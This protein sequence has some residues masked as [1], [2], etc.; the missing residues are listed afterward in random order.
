VVAT[1]LGLQSCS[2]KKDVQPAFTLQTGVTLES[3][4]GCIDNFGGQHISIKPTADGYLVSA[5]T[6][7]QCETR[8]VRPFMTA[9]LDRR[10]TLVLGHGVRGR[11]CECP[12]TV[13]IAIRGRTEP[14]EVLYV[15]NDYE[16]IGHFTVP[17]RAR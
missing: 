9:T 5:T 12:R 10:T 2:D 7:L 15:L 13:G 1:L 17:A 6:V 14:G 16:V 11:S 3:A 8:D 4:S